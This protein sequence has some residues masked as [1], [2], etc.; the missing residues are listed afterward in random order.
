MDRSSVGWVA[1]GSA[2]AVV[3][4][5]AL[6]AFA[7]G[8][9]VS[10]RPGAPD[11][12]LLTQLYHTAGLLVLGGMDLGTPVSGAF[13]PRALLWAAYF[14]APLITTTAVVEGVLRLVASTFDVLAL[15]HAAGVAL[16]TED[17]LLNLEVGFRLARRYPRLSNVAHVSNISLNRAAA[18]VGAPNEA[19]RLHVFNA[20]RVS[21][22]HLFHNY[23]ENYFELTDSKDR[24]V[25]AGFGRFGQTI[26]EL[27]EQQAS[28]D[29]ATMVVADHTASVRWRTFRAQVPAANGPDPE[30]VDGDL[31]DPQTWL[32]MKQRLGAPVDPPGGDRR[33]RR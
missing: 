29:I 20:H 17:D 15:E 33:L 26:Y 25:L 23:L 31:S 14:L 10:D 30:V 13:A 28:A 22:E 16:L 19:G 18:D 3:F 24:V 4:A 2:L 5:M 27:L 9:D 12:D 6:Y 7:A 1:R 11:A 32:R 21:A 8:V